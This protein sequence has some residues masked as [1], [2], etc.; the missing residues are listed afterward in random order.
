MLLSMIIKLWEELYNMK[1]SDMIHVGT[2]VG[3]HGVRG[4]IK[5]RMYVEDSK[6]LFD[7]E[8]ISTNEE[9]CRLLFNHNVRGNVVCRLHLCAENR[10]VTDRN[11]AEELVGYKFFMPS[12]IL[13][14]NEDDTFFYRDLKNLVVYDDAMHRLGYI[15][16]VDNYGA[17]DV[18]SISFDIAD[19]KPE[20][21]LPFSKDLFL[22]VT[23]SHAI[24]SNAA[25][26]Y[27]L[28]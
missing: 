3:V 14:N 25:R 1:K 10:I 27:C 24:L 13:S 15:S 16:N 4:L 19:Y 17:G 21:M 2:V 7:N 5:V 22:D 26:E 12:S 28:K 18:V 23:K 6:M 9:P 11:E 8:L 20:V